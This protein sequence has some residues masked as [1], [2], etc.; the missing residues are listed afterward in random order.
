GMGVWNDC[1][2]C[3]AEAG[4]A[5][6]DVL[7]ATAAERRIAGLGE[8]LEVGNSSDELHREVGRYAATHGVDLLIGVRG[9][10]LAMV[11]EASA[12]G[13]DARF[14]DDPAEA[15]KLVRDQARPGDALLFKGSR[16][17]KVELALAELLQ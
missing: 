3:N 2:N 14:L 12:A 11:E 5:M 13:L 8:M 15:G 9:S 7:R 4:E 1:C 17:V 16:G 6:L 10:A